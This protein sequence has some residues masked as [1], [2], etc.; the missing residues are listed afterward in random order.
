MKTWLL[1][2]NFLASQWYIHGASQ[3]H[4]PMQEMWVQSLSPEDS[5][6]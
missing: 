4:L 5:L 6:E 3:N 2:L 1:Y